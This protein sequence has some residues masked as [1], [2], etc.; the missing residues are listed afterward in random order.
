M[1]KIFFLI[2]FLV[3]VFFLVGACSFGKAVDT[4]ST[5]K[6]DLSEESDTGE[7]VEESTLDEAKTEDEEE[8]IVEEGPV[9]VTKTDCL[10]NEECINGA[11]AEMVTIYDTA[12]ECD[13]KCN[14]DE[15]VVSTSDGDELLLSRGQGSYT[16][17]GAVEWQLLAGADYCKEEGE[18]TVVAIKLKK[19]NSGEILSEEVVTVEVGQESELITHPTI[20][21]VQFTL[22][23][24]SINEQ[25]S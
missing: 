9:C 4:G 16:A 19:K 13:S 12:S 6:V 22:T 3:L 21:R 7:E 17:A 11:C 8:I 24:E 23:V 18:E 25:C 2:G 1:K 20:S 15:V 5:V 10:W 14:F